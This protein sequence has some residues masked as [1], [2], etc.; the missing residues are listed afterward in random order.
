[1]IL[2]YMGNVYASMLKTN[3]GGVI[4]M[5]TY[6]DPDSADAVLFAT[7]MLASEEDVHHWVR[8]MFRDQPWETR[9]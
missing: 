4:A 2:G 6:G 3:D 8:R 1:M 5:L 9:Q 7:E